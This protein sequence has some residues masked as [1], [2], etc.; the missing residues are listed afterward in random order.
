MRNSA[1]LLLICA[2]SPVWA[3]TDPNPPASYLPLEVGTVWEYEIERSVW[4]FVSRFQRETI[5][6]DTLISGARYAVLERRLYSWQVQAPYANEGTVAFVRFD[7]ER[8]N[9]VERLP[10]GSER[11]YLTACRLDLA[12]DAAPASCGNT[13]TYLEANATTAIAVSRDTVEASTKVFSSGTDT[14]IVA[15]G[16]GVIEQ[17]ICRDY[18]LSV[19]LTYTQVGSKEYGFSQVGAFGQTIADPVE[20]WRYYP[21]AVGDRWEYASGYALSGEPV[22]DQWQRVRVDSDT[23]IAGVYYLKRILEAFVHTPN[24]DGYSTRQDFVRYDSVSTSIMR[25]SEEEQAEFAITYPLSS[26]LLNALYG[27]ACLKEERGCY[28]VNGR[29][30]A[31]A[32]GTVF[33]AI[34][35]F[36]VPQAD[37][38]L[39]AEYLANV[40]PTNRTVT[41]FGP[42]YVTDFAY[43]SVG[44]IEYGEPVF[45]RAVDAEDAP[46]VVAFAAGAF[47]NPTHGSTTLRIGMSEQQDVRIAVFDVLG[48][49]VWQDERYLNAGTSAV[50]I[51]SASWPGGVYFARVQTSGGTETVRIT[52]R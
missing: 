49:S 38:G 46:P 31:R 45:D 37:P 35:S 15:S 52:K 23:L 43:A 42:T 50:A 19:R 20:P 40:G 48:R 4:P 32:F 30:D 26:P 36:I 18:C 2:I 39:V 9:V 28:V 3:Q 29:V 6:R 44:G 14:T 34:K 1:L 13:E 41:A 7:A 25:W 22:F 16:L 21:L 8:G 51:D 10:D 11:P 17:S 33:P 47:P 27:D 12:F 24:D 5:A